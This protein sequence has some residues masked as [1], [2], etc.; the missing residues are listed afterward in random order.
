MLWK[1]EH[2]LLEQMLHFPEYFQKNSKLNLKVLWTLKK[3]FF[4]LLL[5]KN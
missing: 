5:I 2:L 3:T 1:M 4:K